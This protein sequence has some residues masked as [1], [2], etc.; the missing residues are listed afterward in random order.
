[1]RC[2]KCGSAR[3]AVVDSRDAVGERYK[4]RKRRCLACGYRFE[5]VECVLP[6]LPVDTV[7]TV[8]RHGVDWNKGKK[9]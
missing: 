8:K 5:T 9:G 2:G 7:A 4:Y 6:D 3:N 1:V